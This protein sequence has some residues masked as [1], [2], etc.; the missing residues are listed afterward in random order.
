MQVMLLAAGLSTRLGPLGASLPKPL[1]PIC[2]YP[3]IAFGLALCRRSGLA[4]VVVNLHHHGDLVRKALGDGSRFGVSL[5]YS[6]EDELLGT[7]GGLV[8]A[9]PLFGP[10]PVL[11]MNAKIVADV[12]LAEVIAAH[13]A[14]PPGTLATMVVREDTQP[15]AWSPVGVDATGHV[16]SLRGQRSD[17]TPVGPVGLRMF[18]GIQVI[19][20]ALIDRLPAGVSDVV[21]DAHIPAL[22]DGARINST[23]ARRFFADPSTP[24]R[25]LDANLALLSEAE[26]FACSPGPLVGVDPQAAVHAEARVV[27]PCRLAASAVIEAGA[28]VGPFVVVCE[29]GRVAAGARV[30]R[31]VIWSGAVA[32]GEVRDRIVS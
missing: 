17:R 1:I 19:E 9:R 12:D 6:E 25:Y 31:S 16:I 28:V 26:G 27:P 30:E 3:A 20:P 23:L 29:G 13:R 4:D 14:A 24:E 2:G 8:K 21:A 22:L 11:V 32:E 18:T 5:R 7:G 10:G 15:G